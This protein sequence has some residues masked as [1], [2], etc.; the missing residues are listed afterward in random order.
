MIACAGGTTPEDSAPPHVPSP[1][2][3]ACWAEERDVGGAEVATGDLG[4]TPQV[5]VMGC[6]SIP[7]EAPTHGIRWVAP[8]DATWL[9]RVHYA[10]LGVLQVA[11][12][13]DAEPVCVDAE[14]HQVTL[15]A[16]QS[17][18]LTLRGYGPYTLGVV[19]APDAAQGELDCGDGNDD[20]LDG[21]IDC[22]DADCVAAAACA[23]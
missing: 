10:D 17:V 6:C 9:M 19:D 1:D 4:G 22:D 2:D 7:P 8:R 11:D 21:S 16:G 18:I 3:G 14:A 15:A 12:T 5:P 20:D 13:C 23:G